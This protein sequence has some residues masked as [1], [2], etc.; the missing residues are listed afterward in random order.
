MAHWLIKSAVHRGISA[1]PNRQFWNGLLQK[2]ITRSTELTP[3]T[4]ED[5]ARECA[6]HLRVFRSARPEGDF[7]A[8]ELGTGWLPIIPVGLCLCGAREVWTFDIDHLLK[9]ER[10]LNVLRH[11]RDYAERGTLGDL[12]PEARAD[13]VQKLEAV[14]A[15]AKTD[16]PPEA[17]LE[18]LGIHYLVRDA[19]QLP[20]PE[21]TIDF[22]ASSG[23]LE[24]VPKPALPRVLKEFRRVGAPG[25][26]MSHR[27]NL[28]DQY[29]H[30]DQN[31]TAFNFLRF[32]QREWSW[33]DSPLMSQNRLRIN[34]Y[35]RCF[36]EAGFEIIQEEN[37]SGLPQDL[38]RIKLAPE[39]QQMTQED[40]L[41]LHSYISARRMD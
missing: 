7:T 10:L 25:A 5:K 40:L 18:K 24:Y 29:S 14:V 38:A 27:S 16:E 33:L 6:R 31:I 36:S 15:S 26:R 34:D 21:G 9:T 2:W 17:L 28:V 8:L 30:F 39:F 23:V 32:T 3:R 4:F 11:Y 12:L 19:Q 22:F 13:R 41:V 35:R 20:L 1:L 37:V